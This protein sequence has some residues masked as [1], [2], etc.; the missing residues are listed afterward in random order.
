MAV[1]VCWK[2]KRPNYKY[3]RIALPDTLFQIILEGIRGSTALSDVAI[4]DISIHFGTCSGDV[5][6]CGE[7]KKI[8]KIDPHANSF[9][10]AVAENPKL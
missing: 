8:N 1:P 6:L 3:L 10:D 5:N 9:I 2:D 7:S 4:D